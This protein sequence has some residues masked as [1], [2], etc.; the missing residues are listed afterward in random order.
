M[1]FYFAEQQPLRRSREGE[2]S[3]LVA[4]AAFAGCTAAVA[5]RGRA[6]GVDNRILAADLR[7]TARAATTMS[8]RASADRSRNDET[9]AG[10][11]PREG[12]RA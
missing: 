10:P 7:R 1:T 5:P 8:S 4:D 9:P 12:L 3:K 6:W 2:I 11:K